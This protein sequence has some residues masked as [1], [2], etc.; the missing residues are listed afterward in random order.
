MCFTYKYRDI[1]VPCIGAVGTIHILKALEN[2]ADGV[3]LMGCLEGN[4][5]YLTGNLRARKRVQYVKK[6][7]GKLSIE[8]ER[9]EIYNLSSAEANRFCK[10][11]GE[12]T[13]KVRTL[14][15]IPLK[16]DNSK[17]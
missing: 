3:C 5:E 17:I 15:P 9:L 16:I 6:L 12:I 8:K 13:E 14:G 4:C 7:L 10:L 11:A 2:G 1:K